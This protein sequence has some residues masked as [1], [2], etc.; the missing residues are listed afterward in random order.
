MEV[1]VKMLRIVMDSAGDA[2]PGWADEFGIDI[3]PINIHFGEK[4]FL[5]GVELN[6]KDF[7]QMADQGG[8]YPKTSQPSPQQFIQFYRRIAQLGDTILSVHVT[9][10]LSGTLASAEMA[11]REL[12][13]KYKIIPFD[14]ASG[15]AAMGFMCREARLMDRAG[16][17]VEKIV[18][19][20]KFISRSTHIVLTLATLEYARRSG[21]V[22]ALQ[23]AL[24]SLLNVKPII[25]L[26]EGMLELGDRVRTRSKSMDHILELMVLRFGDRLVNAAVVHS[27]DP[28]SAQVLLEMVRNRLN[29]KE[30]ITTELSIGIAA[31]L[32]PGT[33]GIIAFPA[34]GG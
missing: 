25:S 14:S 3:I 33:V 19:R 34:E 20:L 27:E 16:E 32:G 24:A 29:V 12:I 26:R 21:R 22:K 1:L 23:A 28:G 30:L 31:N 13:G 9:G 10:K 4:M 15:S 5:Q 7:Y 2:P 11:A 18:E 8:I 6:N 17:Q